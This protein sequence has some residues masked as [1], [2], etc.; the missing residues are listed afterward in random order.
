MDNDQKA[1]QML[2]F[3]GAI[4]VS[5]LSGSTL[6]T[7]ISIDGI[8]LWR[9]RAVSF[10][11]RGRATNISNTISLVNFYQSHNERVAGKITKEQ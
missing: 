11:A 3:S 7:Y 6:S 2:D 10:F 1:S 4:Q 8:V 5:Q 9:S